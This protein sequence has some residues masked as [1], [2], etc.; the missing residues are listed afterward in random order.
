MELGGTEALLLK[1]NFIERESKPN[2]LNL[3]GEDFFVKKLF[4]CLGS[5]SPR[6]YHP[7]SICCTTQ[8]LAASLTTKLLARN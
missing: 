2:V 7:S 8:L 5:W 4:G 3:R 1:D 6:L